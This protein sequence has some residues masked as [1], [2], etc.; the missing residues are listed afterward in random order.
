MLSKD[1]FLLIKIEYSLQSNECW[2]NIGQINTIIFNAG[3]FSLNII[4]ALTMAEK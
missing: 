3:I 4:M 2:M 1:L